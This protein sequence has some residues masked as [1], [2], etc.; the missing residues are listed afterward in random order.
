MLSTIVKG[1]CSAQFQRRTQVRGQ[2]FVKFLYRILAVTAVA[3]YRAIPACILLKIV[4]DNVHTCS[5][6]ISDLW[7]AYLHPTYPMNTY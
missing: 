6:F 7:A 1:S 2:D 3:K 5:Y 4:C